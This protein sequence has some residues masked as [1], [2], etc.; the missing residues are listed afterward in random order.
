VIGGLSS[1]AIACLVPPAAWTSQPVKY[2]FLLP[3]IVI[4]VILYGIWL[5]IR[6][7]LA[8][9][10][11][12]KLILHPQMPINPQFIKHQTLLDHDTDKVIFANS[13]TLTP[14][15]IT[16]DISGNELTIH[17]LDEASAEDIRTGAM[18]K[19]IFGIFFSRK[20]KKS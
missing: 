6:I 5:L 15:T 2:F 19:Q 16:A 20:K 9:F 10:H 18:E 4:R 14:G 11:V 1:A 7:F 13:I 3:L 12:S 17:Q 8:A